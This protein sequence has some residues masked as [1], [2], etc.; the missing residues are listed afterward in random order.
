MSEYPGGW[1]GESWGAPVCEPDRHM[2]TPV[3]D[4]CVDCAQLITADDRGMIIPFAGMTPPVLES[5]HLDCFLRIVMPEGLRDEIDKQVF[6]RPV[7]TEEFRAMSDSDD[8][9]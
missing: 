8:V 5:H 9:G 2:P 4:K 6:G 7:S 3:G 1:F